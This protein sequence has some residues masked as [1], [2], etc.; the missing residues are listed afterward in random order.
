MNGTGNNKTVI[1]QTN[2]MEQ[3]HFK[4]LRVAE[5]VKKFVAFSGP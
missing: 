5:E 3:T 2:T 4:E 1:K